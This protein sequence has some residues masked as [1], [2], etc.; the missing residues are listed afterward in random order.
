[1]EL[2]VEAQP[3]FEA[4]RAWRAEAARDQGV[5]AYI[6]FGDATLRGIALT[7]PSS[8]AELGT[9]SGVGEKK[10]ESYGEGVLAVVG[11]FTSDAS[12]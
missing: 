2:P 8:L 4:L 9:I 5:P 3:L 10:L 7:R 11:G 12:A 1:A 6:V